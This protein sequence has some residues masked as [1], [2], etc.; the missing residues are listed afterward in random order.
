L[1]EIS[2]ADIPGLVKFDHS[3]QP[4]PQNRAVYDERFAIFTDVYKHMRG[5]YRTLNA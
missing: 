3:Y 1:G 2:F 4:R 5:I